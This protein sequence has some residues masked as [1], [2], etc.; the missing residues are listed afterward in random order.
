MSL[1]IAECQMR[2]SSNKKKY[3]RLL[4]AKLCIYIFCVTKH[5]DSFRSMC[6]EDSF[7]F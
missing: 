5:D 1:E 3:F 6:D 4:N 2:S 7:I